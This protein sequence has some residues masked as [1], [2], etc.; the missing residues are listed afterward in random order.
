[1]RTSSLGAPAE[2]LRAE[3]EQFL[4]AVRRCEP[5]AWLLFRHAPMIPHLFSDSTAADSHLFSGDCDVVQWPS[6]RWLNRLQ[7]QI[8]H[9]FSGDC[10]VVRVAFAEVAE[11]MRRGASAE[12]NTLSQRRFRRIV[13][14]VRRTRMYAFQAS[15]P[16]SRPPPVSFSPPNAPPISAPDVPMLTF[17]MPQSEPSGPRKRSA[18]RMSVVKIDDESPL[19]HRIVQSDGLVEVS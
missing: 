9:L 3:P 12:L 16:D 15:E 8:P 4:A 17:A 11:Q 13:D 6:Q 1:M 18:S 10:D 5:S 7:G 14:G 19:R 2:N